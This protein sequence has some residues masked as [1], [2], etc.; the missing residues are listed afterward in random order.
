[1]WAGRPQLLRLCLFG[2]MN[3]A[4]F[5]DL[6]ARLRHALGDD[7]IGIGAAPTQAAL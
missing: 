6:V 3:P 4:S 5:P 1:M 7:V 2:S